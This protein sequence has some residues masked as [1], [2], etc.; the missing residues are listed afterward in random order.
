MAMLRTGHCALR[1]GL[2]DGP[3]LTPIQ[4]QE[5]HRPSEPNHSPVAQRSREAA[6]LLHQPEVGF[7][8]EGGAWKR[9]PV[10]QT[11]SFVSLE[12]APK[13]V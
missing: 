13:Q 4:R 1:P 7:Q 8:R 11:L 6:F 5:L 9:N 3:S 10:T 2:S 12:R